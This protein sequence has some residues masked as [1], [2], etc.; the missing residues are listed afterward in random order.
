MVWYNPNISAAQA[1]Q[2]LAEVRYDA[3]KFGSVNTPYN[4][5]VNPV[6][7]GI[8]DALNEAI[9]KNEIITAGMQAKGYQLVRRKSLEEQAALPR[10][11]NRAPSELRQNAAP[12]RT[13]YD[14]NGTQYLQQ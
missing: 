8:G 2:D 5:R 11:S 6:A 7:A 9:R 12:R 1:R 10:T 4:P 13:T 14:S 3:V